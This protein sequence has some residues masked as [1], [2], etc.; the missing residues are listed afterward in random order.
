MEKKGEEWSVKE[1]KRKGVVNKYTW[2]VNGDIEL[3]KPDGDLRK[4]LRSSLQCVREL[5]RQVQLSVRLRAM[6]NK[7]GSEMVS[8]EICGLRRGLRMEA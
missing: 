1:R 4:M 5:R 7:C 6:E 2:P 8:Q 3:E